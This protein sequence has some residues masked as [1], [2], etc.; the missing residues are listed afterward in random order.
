MIKKFKIVRINTDYCDFLRLFDNKVMYNMNQKATRPF[1]GVLF[2]IESF[3][4][5]APLSS[6]KE[7]HKTMKNTLDFFKIKNRRVRSNK[8]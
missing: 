8:L 7:K 6:P 2:E 3:E 4:Y 1:V 5:F